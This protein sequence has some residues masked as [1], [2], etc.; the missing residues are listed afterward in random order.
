[1]PRSS[2][3]YLL[4]GAALAILVLAALLFFVFGGDAPAT[5]P[6]TSRAAPVNNRKGDTPPLEQPRQTAPPPGNT[7]APAPAETPPPVHDWGPNDPRRTP[8]IEVPA[9]PP[10]EKRPP[11]EGE[12]GETIPP[13]ARV[14]D[15]SGQAMQAHRDLDL[16]MRV[17]HDLMR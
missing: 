7:P 10:I 16:T 11:H 15:L 5:Q 9:P 2:T 6:A 8:P 17:L 13:S 1:M 14:S 4:G 3:P 12:E